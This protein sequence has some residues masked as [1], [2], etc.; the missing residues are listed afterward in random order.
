MMDKVLVTAES[1]G[2]SSA[3]SNDSNM[4]GRGGGE[5]NCHVDNH[6]QKASRIHDEQAFQLLR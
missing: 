4:Q 6:I 3:G 2:F 5:C 1:L